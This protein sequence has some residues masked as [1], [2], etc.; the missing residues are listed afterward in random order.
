MNTT[1]DQ[2]TKKKGGC[3]KWGLIFIVIN[4]FFTIIVGVFSDDK[5]ENNKEESNLIKLKD[6][7]C[8][9]VWSKLSRDQKKELLED[10]ITN[11]DSKN[12]IE[13]SINNIR[14]SDAVGLKKYVGLDAYNFLTKAVKYPNTILINGEKI[15]NQMIIFLNQDE[16]I[17]DVDKG[18]IVY[19]KEFTSENKLGM[20]VKGKFW[21]YVKY[22]AGCKDYEVIDFKI[23]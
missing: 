9:A 3:L 10:F 11:S 23:E 16:S 20:Q 6:K 15:D 18:T 13:S 7:H 1:I 5:I 21:M 17:Y 12:E 22:N 8:K 2:K 14:L 4:I 19:S